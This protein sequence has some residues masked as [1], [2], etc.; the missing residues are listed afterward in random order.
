MQEGAER[1]ALRELKE[2][3]RDN[4]SSQPKLPATFSFGS[5]RKLGEVQISGCRPR[6]LRLF[7][8][9]LDRVHSSGGHS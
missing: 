2:V 7:P 9:H 4:I 6:L 8:S 3:L 1:D 5:D